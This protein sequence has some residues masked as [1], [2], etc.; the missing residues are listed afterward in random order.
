MF[1]NLHKALFTAYAF[2]LLP[3]CMLSK[4]KLHKWI[5]C[6]LEYVV[7]IHWSLHNNNKHTFIYNKWPNML[8]PTASHLLF[9]EDNKCKSPVVIPLKSCQLPRWWTQNR[10]QCAARFRN[11]WTLLLN[12]F[13]FFRCVAWQHQE[14]FKNVF[15][16]AYVFKKSFNREI[17]FV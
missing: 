3:G 13:T 17:Y 1:I 15:H 5:N 11:T 4:L 6:S 7:I 10:P 8:A 9:Q 14:H 2:F 16:L 12:Y